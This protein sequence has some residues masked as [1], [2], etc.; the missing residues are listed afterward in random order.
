MKKLVSFLTLEL[1]L[2]K[3]S[4]EKEDGSVS[5]AIII[6]KPALPRHVSRKVLG[7]HPS[8]HQSFFINFRLEL[9]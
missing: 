3:K 1:I 5:W 4:Q 8:P 9:C 6:V 2:I 7:E